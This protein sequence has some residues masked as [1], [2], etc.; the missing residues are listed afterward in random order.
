MAGAE[1]ETAEQKE[2]YS[3]KSR[4]GTVITTKLRS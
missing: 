2:D 1:S 3:R 4:G